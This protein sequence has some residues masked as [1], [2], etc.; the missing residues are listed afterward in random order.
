NSSKGLECYKPEG[1]FYLFPSCIK[2][3]GLK[4]PSGNVLH[5]SNDVAEY[6]LEDAEAAVVP[7]VAFGME[8]YFRIS[9]AMSME[10][11]EKACLRIKDSC[12][13]LYA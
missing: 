1:A 3:F 10:D 6:F 5:N 9:Y 13:K 7:G 11:L 2:L 8:G 12:E 4:T